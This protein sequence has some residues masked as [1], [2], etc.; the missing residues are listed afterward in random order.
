[1]IILT[2]KEFRKLNNKCFG[3]K[4]A[5]NYNEVRADINFNLLKDVLT[6]TF[7]FYTVYGLELELNL[8]HQ[9]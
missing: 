9:L 5:V 1:M 7:N 4:L 2:N 3:Y 8:K 6:E